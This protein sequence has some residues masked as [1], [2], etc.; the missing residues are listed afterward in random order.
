MIGP[1]GIEGWDQAVDKKR[2]AARVHFYDD[3]E[4][5]LPT[6]T[7]FL[8]AIIEDQREE[9]ATTQEK[10]ERLADEWRAFND[11]MSYIEYGHVAY[12]QIIGMGPFVVPFL[13]RGLARG[14]DEWVP[15]LK[16]IVG[17]REHSASGG[18]A[19]LIKKAWL[20][21]GARNGYPTGA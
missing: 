3:D 5:R 20:E 15:A 11:G 14:E 19:E 4:L 12:L 6:P 17:D 21:W 7:P 16:Y 8:T 9:F 1:P 13:L 18:N 10:F 2:K